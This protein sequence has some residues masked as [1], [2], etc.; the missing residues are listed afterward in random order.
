[1]LNYA[2]HHEGV[3]GSGCID[4]I[5]LTSALVDEW[6]ASR[7]A[8]FTPAE[9]LVREP[10]ETSWLTDGADVAVPRKS[11]RKEVHRDPEDLPKGG[12]TVGLFG[13]NNPKKEAV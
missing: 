12:R 4:S 9:Q 8:R 11:P 1:V 13:T 2:L 10:L 3:W 5:F 6:S 7:P